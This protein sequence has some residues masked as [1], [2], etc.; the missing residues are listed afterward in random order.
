MCADAYI[1][2]YMSS[3]NMV[4]PDWSRVPRSRVPP[5]TTVRTHRSDSGASLCD[6]NWALGRRPPDACRRSIRWGSGRSYREPRST[7]TAWS[8]GSSSGSPCT[9]RAGYRPRSGSRGFPNP[10][11]GYSFWSRLCYRRF[12][13]RET[14]TACNEKWKHDDGDAL[15]LM[16]LLSVLRGWNYSATSLEFLASR[17]RAPVCGFPWLIDSRL[18][19]DHKSVTAWQSPSLIVVFAFLRLSPNRIN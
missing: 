7:L 12:R 3:N 19:G 16:E 17:N 10:C 9:S 18:S 4:P 6:S 5:R 1:P 11:S 2:G 15:T 8:R 14:H 13:L